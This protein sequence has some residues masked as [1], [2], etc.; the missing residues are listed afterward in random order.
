MWQI[1]DLRQTI[2]KPADD[3]CG[4]FLPAEAFPESLDQD[5]LED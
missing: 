3:F 1:F 5:V 2:P 4:V